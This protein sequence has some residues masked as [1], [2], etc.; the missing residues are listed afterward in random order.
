MLKRDTRVQIIIIEK[1]KYILL[2]HHAIKTGVFFWGIPG[3]GREA[4]ET[5]EEAAIRE[6]YEET[7]LKV[8]LLPIKIEGVHKMKPPMYNRIVTFLAYPIEGKAKVGYEPEVEMKQ[9]YELVDIKLQDFY[10]DDDIGE[11]TIDYIKEFRKIVDSDR[12]IKKKYI[13]YT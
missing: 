10:D 3:G 9:E 11:L 7:S 13:Y 12:F 6:T 4:G 5:D 1:G 2:K 8:K